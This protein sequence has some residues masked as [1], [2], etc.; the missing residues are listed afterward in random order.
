MVQNLLNTFQT[1]L[2]RT[3]ACRRQPPWIRKESLAT[4]LLIDI[5]FIIAGVA[6]VQH[7]TSENCLQRA[8]IAAYAHRWQKAALRG[9]E[10]GVNFTSF[11]SKC[12]KHNNTVGKTR[13][14]AFLNSNFYWDWIKNAQEIHQWKS[15]KLDQ[16]SYV[17]RSRE[18]FGLPTVTSKSNFSLKINQPLSFM[19]H[20]IV[21]K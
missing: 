2:F 19:L 13:H 15:L 6:Y 5:D 17:E 12:N 8:V 18:H 3:S 16:L 4:A 10:I 11:F 1:T 14:E 20:L 9:T 7:S 21:F